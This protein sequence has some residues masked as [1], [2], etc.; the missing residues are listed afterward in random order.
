M[1][2]ERRASPS[3]SPSPGGR[4]NAM[5]Y[6]SSQ[7]ELE[8]ERP[9]ALEVDFSTPLVRAAWAELVGMSEPAVVAASDPDAMYVASPPS[10]VQPV[11]G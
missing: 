10:P 5:G 4:Y 11:E 6:H 3:P 8:W 9:D 1:G 2:S 7:G